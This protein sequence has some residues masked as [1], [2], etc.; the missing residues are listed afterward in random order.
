MK[1]NLVITFVSKNKTSINEPKI[2]EK[3]TNDNVIFIYFDNLSKI[4]EY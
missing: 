3:Y 2:E 4:G 1:Y